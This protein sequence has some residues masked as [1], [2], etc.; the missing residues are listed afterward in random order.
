MTPSI[1]DAPR[2]APSGGPLITVVVPTMLR[3]E[4]RR[5]LQSVRTQAESPRVEI[6]V[7]ADRAQDSAQVDNLGDMADTVLFSGGGAGAG[8]CRNLGVA[9]AEGD[10]IAFLDDDDEWLPGHLH[11]VLDVIQS[12]DDIDVLSCRAVQRLA[13]S[14]HDSSPVPGRVLDHQPVLDYLFVDRGPSLQRPSIFTSTLL[15]SNHVAAKVRWDDTLSRHQDWDWLRRAQDEGARII[16]SHHVG[17][18]IWV[19]SS[20]SIS[21]STDWESSLAWA[22]SWQGTQSRRAFVDFIAGQPLRY[23]MS[24]RSASGVVA[25]VR[26]MVRGRR[27]PSFRS[28]LLGMG[29]AVP[30]GL[31]FRGLLRLRPARAS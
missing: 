6:V 23:A 29:G 18:R 26:A 22:A 13:G 21:A 19:G 14:P 3:P 11:E 31:A 15:V 10:W 2:R 9:A 12:R 30:R 20:A 27:V 17:V 25:C 28:L 1:A 7:V 8:R 24:A 4:L 5:A 16:Q